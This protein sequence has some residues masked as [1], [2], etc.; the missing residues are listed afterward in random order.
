MLVSASRR[1]A[2]SSALRRVA[3]STTTHARVAQ[4]I[5]SKQRLFPVD[6]TIDPV[7]EMLEVK[8]LIQ[9]DEVSQF[10]F[11]FLRDN[12][13]CSECFHQKSSSRLTAFSRLNLD[14]SIV[15][16]EATVAS[17]R[18]TRLGRATADAANGEAFTEPTACI[19]VGW[20]SGHESLFSLRWLAERCFGQ[21]RQKLRSQDMDT[22]AL[23]EAS[24]VAHGVN[25]E[26]VRASALP[27]RGAR[28]AQ[29]RAI[30]RFKFE[31][32]NSDSDSH[33]MLGWCH[34]LE[35]FGVAIV[36]TD[37]H[38]GVLKHLTQL[39][40]F[41]EWCSYGE[42]YLV[43]NK[44]APAD[45]ATGGRKADANNLAY[46]GLPLPFHTDLPHYASPPQVQLLHCISQ[47]SCEGGAN[48]LVDGFAVGEQL[49]EHHREAFEL[50][51]T[52]QMEYKD[53]HRETL[54]DSG[55][56]GNDE[57]DGAALGGRPN[58]TP[59]MGNSREV[60]FFL[61]HAHPIIS[62]DDARQLGTSRIAR[63]NYSD[64]H[65]DSVL[66]N[67]SAQQVKQYYRACTLF[68]ELLN[69]E[70]NVLWNKSKPGDILCFD[71]RRVLHGR[72]GFEIREGETRKLIGTYLRW[73]EVR[74]M[75]RVKASRSFP[76]R[77]I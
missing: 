46:T 68:D 56:G 18:D 50:L 76:D 32:L 26:E 57:S 55:P 71:N 64:H 45:E 30:P 5:V 12:C 48:K 58:D 21:S 34:A 60:D 74:S 40:G 59:R 11:V 17:V 77:L 3:Q 15:S 36:E 73:D 7:A 49:R 39:F 1:L 63:I 20:S 35:K 4:P 9:E 13:T 37:N 38:A 54:W 24:Q 19:R 53:F 42:F 62:L 70:H 10:P 27:I 31:E 16:V 65:R 29:A 28:E 69:A 47:A 52:V 72:S 6:V 67:V 75:A 23:L 41:R 33:A 51:A 44:V 22:F 43:E 8:H 61:R 66:N 2:R 25:D 14:D